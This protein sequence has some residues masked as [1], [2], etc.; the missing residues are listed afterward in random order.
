MPRTAPDNHVVEYAK[1]DGSILRAR[2]EERP[3]GTYALDLRKFSRGRPTLKP[4]GAANGT[5]NFGEARELAIKELAAI[6]DGQAVG[7]REA[8]EGPITQIEKYIE[9]KMR[10]GEMTQHTGASATTCIIRCWSILQ[11]EYKLSSWREFRKLHMQGLTDGLYALE[12]NGRTIKINTVLKHLNYLKGFIAHLEGIE[13]IESSPVHRHDLV[14][15][16]DKSFEREWLEPWEMGKLLETSVK[17]RESY[18]HKAC[19]AWPEILATEAYTGAREREI[20]GLEVRDLS[21][22]GGKH[23]AGTLHFRPNRW[24][25]LKRKDSKGRLFSLWPGHAAILKAYVKRE[26]P[27]ADGLLFPNPR[28]GMWRELRESMARDLKAAGITKHITD[29]SFRHS[30]ITARSRMYARHL[31]GGRVVER[32]VHVVDIQAEVG[33]TAKSAVTEIYTHESLHPVEGWVELDY[34]RAWAEHQAA[35]TPSG[36]AKQKSKPTGTKRAKREAPAR[37]ATALRVRKNLL[38]KP[39]T[40]RTAS[41]RARRSSS[42]SSR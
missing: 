40:G 18:N 41:A 30:Y 21:F 12:Y 26:R 24:R 25:R 13:K 20:L 16:L 42:K 9:G 35:L 19:R 29:H 23:G 15:S 6:A 32:P 36:K 4:T 27:P 14:P 37:Q 3:E 8:L 33:H 17:G 22:S 7:T 34:A 31:E 10:A 28:G 11:K 2:I 5:K 38:T 39:P 1:E